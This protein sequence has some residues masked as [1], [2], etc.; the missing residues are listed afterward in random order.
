MPQICST[1]APHPQHLNCRLNLGTR[2]KT[3]QNPYIRLIFAFLVMLTLCLPASSAAQVSVGI[4]VAFAPP[5]L[6]VYEQ[7]ICPEEGYIW[8]P[9]YW[10]YDPD[11]GDYYWVPG[12]WVL[13]PEV[14]FL[15]TPG[16]WAWAAADSSSMKASGDR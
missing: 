3:M 9:G 12:T 6:P 7:P 1:V 15:W 5:D 11:F 2:S 4:A 14:G 10:A 8:T 16:Y 13:A